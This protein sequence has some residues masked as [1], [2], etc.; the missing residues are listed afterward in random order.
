[1]NG[2]KDVLN[3][4]ITI[5]RIGEQGKFVVLNTSIS[6]LEKE[7][8]KQ[9]EL[10][11]VVQEKPEVC[12]MEHLLRLPVENQCACTNNIECYKRKLSR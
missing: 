6:N 2:I 4:Y 11:A 1:M 7:L 10:T 8:I 5:K 9:L 3:K 12:A